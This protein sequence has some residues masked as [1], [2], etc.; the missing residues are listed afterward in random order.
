[1]VAQ[2][3]TPRTAGG[4]VPGTVPGV[5][6]E[7]TPKGFLESS[8]W[9]ISG[10]ICDVKPTVIWRLISEGK[11]GLVFRLIRTAFCEPMPKAT[12]DVTASAVCGPTW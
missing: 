9:P 4:T 11:L 12:A 8:F 5:V 2:V 3:D 6:S 1:M 10:P 7:A